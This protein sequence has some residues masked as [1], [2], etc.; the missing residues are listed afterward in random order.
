MSAV[1]H[2]H[3]W[4]EIRSIDRCHS[5]DVE[6]HCNGCHETRVDPE[7]RDFSEPG[8]VAFADE[9]CDICRNRVALAGVWPASWGAYV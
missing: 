9:T 1:G 2:V 4:D 3:E 7:P 6:Q 8:A 5:I